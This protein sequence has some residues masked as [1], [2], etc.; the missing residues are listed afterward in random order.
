MYKLNFFKLASIAIVCCFFNVSFSQWNLTG[1]SNA[2]TTS[3]LGTTNA[4]P[5]TLAT[6]SVK[7]MVIDANGKVGIGITSPLGMLAV[8]GSGTT[9]SSNW[10]SVGNPVFVGF[11]ENTAGNADYILAMASNSYNAR[12]VF[13]GRRSRGIL[14]A[15]TRV[16]INDQLLS[17][18]S[19]GYDGS[20][21]Q[22]AASIDF[23]AQEAAYV[24]YVPTGLS[25]L[26][27]YSG[28]NRTERLK[29]SYNGNFNF[30][31]SQ[32][33]INKLNGNVGLGISPVNNFYKLAVLGTGYFS[34]PLTIGN[35]TLPVSDGNTGQVLT[36]NGA[37]A[38]TWTDV[39]SNGGLQWQNDIQGISYSLGNVGI[40][41]TLP[42][43]ALDVNGNTMLGIAENSAVGFDAGFN[44]RLGF[45]K[46]LGSAPVLAASAGNPIIFANT[47]QSD[48]FSN[49]AGATIAERMRIHSNGNIGIGTTNPQAKLEITGQAALK[50]NYDV[51]NYN[52]AEMSIAANFGGIDT[53]RVVIGNYDG[54]SAI[55]AKSNNLSQPRILY[56]N[57]GNNEK[58]IVG[59]VIF[60]TN[61]NNFPYKFAVTGADALINN[62]RVGCGNSGN[63]TNSLFGWDALRYSTGVSN[64]AIGYAALGNNG[65]G[66]YN[67]AVGKGAGYNTNYSGS[68]A[69]GYEC[70]AS[71][72]A[73]AR[74]GN[75]YL[76]SIGGCVNW[77]T[78]SDSRIKK[79]IKLNVPGLEFINKLQPVTYNM[80]L[81][82]AEK[83]LHIPSIK[84]ENP[85]MANLRKAKEQFVYSGFIAQDVEKAA[86]ELNFDFSGVDA[87]KNDRDLYG[88][89]Y[90]EFVVPL[91][92]SVQELSKKNDDLQRQIDELKDALIKVL[93][94]KTPCIS[95][96]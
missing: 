57:P 94:N 13:M 32:L 27:G 77:T 3:F 15:P 72:D 16:N 37:G 62:V 52:S 20:T 91:V 95:I 41:T 76:S 22:N 83:I 1:N 12:P 71:A 2:T 43:E 34:E 48:L 53:D 24:G 21:F 87:A 93:A 25:F 51:I 14:S 9:P 47:D 28:G 68:T 74:I 70:M 63:N 33:T 78:F 4:I 85:I 69:I 42:T 66:S 44:P 46:K 8:K 58:V 55:G 84:D 64:T 81:D 86:K 26:T 50:V 36:T 30:N 88:L 92:K 54:S 6:N 35:Y 11:G 18:I 7:R 80:D 60:P 90:A 38:I 29:I 17:F 96:K 45:V 56:L 82:A 65:T 61:F 73:Q 59:D 39:A 40:G 10:V 79:N 23:V 67:T 75:Q 19:S 5:L 31:G 89:R 49:I